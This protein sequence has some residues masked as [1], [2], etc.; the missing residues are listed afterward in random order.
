LSAPAR[1]RRQTSAA[2]RAKSALEAVAQPGETKRG[3]RPSTKRG[4]FA[5]RMGSRMKLAVSH[6]L[7]REAGIGLGIALLWGGAAPLAAR[8]PEAA[9]LAE[10]AAAMA[11]MHRDMS[12]APSGDV[13]HD[14]VAMMVPH[15]QGA[16]DMARAVLRY[17]QN[18]QVRRLAQEIVVEQEQEIAAMR[19]AVDQSAASPPPPMAAGK[20]EQH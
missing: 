7:R 16:I 11:K 20:P 8:S 17:G 10:N 3:E 1:L 9:F 12:V 14:F 18:E 6:Q 19:L 5:D 13:D 2:D 15:H 4:V